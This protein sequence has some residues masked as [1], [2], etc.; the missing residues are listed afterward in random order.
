MQILK[1]MRCQV[2]F[3]LLTFANC[4]RVVAKNLFCLSW[5]YCCSSWC[6]H[7]ELQSTQGSPL[8]SLTLFSLLGWIWND[9]LSWS[10]ARSSGYRCPR[11]VQ[12]NCSSWLLKIFRSVY[13]PHANCVHWLI[14]RISPAESANKR[15]DR[16]TLHS[17]MADIT[18]SDQTN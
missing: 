17:L 15:D 1:I 18:S 6:C 3:T 13:T 11:S 12:T 4:N 9:I 2:L 5:T 16:T 14:G 7:V 10:E 8:Q